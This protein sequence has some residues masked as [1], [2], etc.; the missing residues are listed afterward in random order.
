MKKTIKINIGG[1]IFHLD[2]DAYQILQNYL[3]AINQRF[4]SSEEGKEIISDIEKHGFSL[5]DSKKTHAAEDALDILEPI[6]NFVYGKNKVETQLEAF[7][8]EI[9][10]NL[11][12]FLG[13]HLEIK[14]LAKLLNSHS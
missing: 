10:I 9:V 4:A 8:V 7:T 11:N 6:L 13:K 2:E 5:P 1:V 3:T 14:K 12:R